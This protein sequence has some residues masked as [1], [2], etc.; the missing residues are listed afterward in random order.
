MTPQ[1]WERAVAWT[2]NLHFNSLGWQKD[3]VRKLQE[4]EDRFDAKLAGNVDMNTI[5][6]IWD[7]YS[8]LCPYGARY[9]RFKPQMMEEIEYDATSPGATAS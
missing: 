2:L 1:Q 3:D 6:W 7:E 9:Q 4:F 8:R 5:H